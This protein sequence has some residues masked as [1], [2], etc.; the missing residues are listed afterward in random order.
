MILL[1]EKKDVGNKNTI[2]ATNKES[3]DYTKDE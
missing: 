2:T 3:K 1:N